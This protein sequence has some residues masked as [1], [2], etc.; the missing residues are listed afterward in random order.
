M[1]TINCK[2]TLCKTVSAATLAMI[3]CVAANPAAAQSAPTAPFPSARFEVLTTSIFPSSEFHLSDTPWFVDYYEWKKRL[4]DERGIDFAVLSA[5]VVQAGSGASDVYADNEVD[6]LFSWRLFENKGGSG[7]L[8]FYGIWVQTLSGKQTGP[9]ASANGVITQPNG[10]GTE[11]NQSF[12]S[13][14]ALWWDQNFTGLGLR[15]RVGQLW[16]TNLYASNTYYGDDRANYMNSILGGGAGV[17]WIGG[18]RGLGA[19]ASV[20]T[21][22]GYVA[23]GVQDSKANQQTID[24]SSFKDGRFSYIGEAGINTD[25]GNGRTGQVKLT[26]GYVDDNGESGAR[27]QDSG[28]GFNL[29]FEQKLNEKFALFGLYRHSFERF[30]ANTEAAA[31][32]GVTAIA[33]FGWD[34]DEASIAIFYNTPAET[35]GGTLRDEIGLEAFYRLQ[36]TP[37]F[38]VTPSALLY[39]RPGQKTQ[40][41]PVGIL[42]LRLRYIL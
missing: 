20:E 19:M 32:L 4:S 8:F 40:K 10:G 5:P 15:Y 18:N 34:D 25:F 11:P 42:G 2:T 29:S 35:Q 17:P 26:A 1:V 30:A 22:F 27:A 23:G 6:L 9:F 41:S 38:D 14:S 3:S 13:P 24:I 21:P 37:R 16:T 39:L 7:R 33:P 12:V 28:W 36:M 31:A